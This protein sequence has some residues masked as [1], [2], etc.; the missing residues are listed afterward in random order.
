MEDDNAEDEVEE[1][2]VE[3][4]DVEKEEDNDVEEDEEKDENVAE[5]EVEEDDVED[6]DVKGEEDDDV[7]DLML[8]MMMLRRRTDPKDH[9][10]CEPAQSKCTSTFHKSHFTRKFTRKRPQTRVSTLIK[11]RPLQLP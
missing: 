5:D 7:E 11:H 1:D 2:K 6:D 10:L 4:D 3:D 9:T 8:S